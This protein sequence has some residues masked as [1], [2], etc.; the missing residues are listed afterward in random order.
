ML[1]WSSNLWSPFL[2][3][4]LSSCFLFRDC[5]S[6]FWKLMMLMLFFHQMSLRLFLVC[7]LQTVLYRKK[8]LTTFLKPEFWLVSFT[9]FAALVETD[10]KGIVGRAVIESIKEHFSAV[11]AYAVTLFSLMPK[12]CAHTSFF[13]LY[14]VLG[15]ER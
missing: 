7:F 13:V 1:K 14:C 15:M 5:G 6:L 2:R 11:C 8:M 12:S 4:K 9:I 10:A 3:F